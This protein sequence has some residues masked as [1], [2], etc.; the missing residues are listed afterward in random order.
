MKQ[1]T[2]LKPLIIPGILALLFVGLAFNY[3]LL[4]DFDKA[5]IALVHKIPSQTQPFLESITILGNFFEDIIL[6]VLIAGWELIRRHYNRALVSILTLLAFPLFFL[7]K[8]TV[9]R[10]RPTGEFIIATG[11]PGFSFPSGHAVTSAA[12]FGLLAVMIFSHTKRPWR[13]IAFGICIFI[14][15]MIGISRVYLGAHYP[16][17]VIAGWILAFMVLSLLRA[18]SIYI[19]SRTSHKVSDTT[20]N[21]ETATT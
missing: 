12:A 18:L 11:L 1:I 14:I 16:T 9:S 13:D 20:E 6:I 8:E 7:V 5:V 2:P 3:S 10:A 15:L 21:P 19:A 17:D 4:A